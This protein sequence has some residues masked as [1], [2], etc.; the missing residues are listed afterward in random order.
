MP[1][2]VGFWEAIDET[3]LAHY[4]DCRYKRRTTLD[5]FGRKP[6]E[7]PNSRQTPP[8]RLLDADHLQPIVAGINCMT[9]S[10]RS[11]SISPTR[12]ST[13]AG[14]QSSLSF[15]CGHAKSVA[16]SRM[17]RRKPSRD[18]CAQWVRGVPRRALYIPIMTENKTD[19][20]AAQQCDS[21]D[22]D[23]EAVDIGD[24]LKTAE[25]TSAVA[26]VGVTL[27]RSR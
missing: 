27:R 11:S 4:P 10:R 17:P 19:E 23:P 13:R 15:D 2:K 6:H 24:G 21:L 9:P 22:I 26:V 18:F 20:T 25:G 14:R 12:T 5:N 1:H 3:L 8:E 16:M 7:R